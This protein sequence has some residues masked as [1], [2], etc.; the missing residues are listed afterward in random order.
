M[1]K[2][3]KAQVSFL[4]GCE[5]TQIAFILVGALDLQWV[6]RDGVTRRLLLAKLGLPSLV[7][8]DLAN[9]ECSRRVAAV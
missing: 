2:L 4:K 3:V 7:R 6:S 1:S 5:G 9:R 8:H